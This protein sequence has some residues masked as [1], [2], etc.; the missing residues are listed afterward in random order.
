MSFDSFWADIIATL[1]GGICLTLLFFVAREKLFPVPEITGRWY[2]EMVTVNT[3]YNPFKGMVLRYVIMIWREG[4]VLKGSAEKI[5]EDSSTGKRNF[6][7]KNRTR[8]NVEGYIERK[9][10]GKDKVYLHSV[11]NGHG[12]ESTNFYDLLVKSESEM[13]GAFNSMVANQDGT[14]T[15]QREPF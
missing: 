14:V 10:L 15:C 7:G 13:I 11:E 3:A 8:A 9:Y 2:I 4:N 12:R 5:Y 1:V 6:V